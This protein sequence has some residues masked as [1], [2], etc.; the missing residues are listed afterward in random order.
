MCR[1]GTDKLGYIT[2]TG[3]GNATFCLGK[4]LQV[5]GKRE[6]A[7][8]SVTDFLLSYENTLSFKDL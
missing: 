5:A 6:C 8:F 7:A 1:A 2:S 4:E 3:E